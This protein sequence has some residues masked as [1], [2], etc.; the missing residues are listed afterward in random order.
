MADTPDTRETIAT[1]GLQNLREI[2]EA[3]VLL[4]LAIESR[5]SGALFIA[6]VKLRAAVNEMRA[7]G[8]RATAVCKSEAARN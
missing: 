1:I 8:K 7:L 2:A 6:T 3:A 5:D 4:D